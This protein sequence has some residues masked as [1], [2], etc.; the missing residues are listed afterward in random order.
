MNTRNTRL[1][2]LIGMRLASFATAALIAV[3][4]LFAVSAIA[5]QSA[6]A[7]DTVEVTQVCPASAVDDPDDESDD[8]DAGEDLWLDDD[9]WLNDDE[10]DLDDEEW[11]EDEFDLDGEGCDDETDEWLS[12]GGDKGYDDTYCGVCWEI[13]WCQCGCGYCTGRYPV[14]RDGEVFGVI[15]VCPGDDYVEAI[16]VVPAVECYADGEI[17]IEQEGDGDMWLDGA[18]ELGDLEDADALYE[19][20]T[21]AP[22]ESE[23]AP[24]EAIAPTMAQLQAVSESAPAAPAVPVQAPQHP[25]AALI[26]RKALVA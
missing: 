14:D 23:I 8:C 5:A 9:S 4:A 13:H 7:S 20:A 3:I 12:D 26:V 2:A 11:A 22:A 16:D 18:E 1:G 24:A 21:F 15:E 19:E 25:D 17:A 6:Y 10:L